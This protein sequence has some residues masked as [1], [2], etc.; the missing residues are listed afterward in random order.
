MKTKLLAL[1]VA[2]MAIVSCNKEANEGAG[3]S[4]RVTLRFSTRAMSD[5]ATRSAASEAENAVE[6]LVVFGLDAEGGVVGAFPVI[7]NPSMTGVELTVPD[8]VVSL[9]VIANPQGHHSLNYAS[10]EEILAETV[11]FSVAPAS[12]FVMSGS[13]SVS[14]AQVDVD[15]VRS[16]AKISVQGNGDFAVNS[17]TVLRTPSKAPLFAGRTNVGEF[18]SHD[19]KAG[20]EVYVGES[21]ASAPAQ[22]LVKGVYKGQPTAY[23]VTLTQ[24]GAP[25][26][27]VRNT[28]YVVGITPLTKT[29][30]LVEV[31]IPEWGDVSGDENLV[32]T[33][34]DYYSVDFHNHTGFSDGT[35]PIAF[36]LNQ[37][38][39][40]GLD[41]IVNSEHGG[42]FSGNASEGDFEGPVPSWTA[43]G[44]L[45][46]I[47]GTPSAGNMWRWQS[48]RDYSFPRV[49]AFNR[50]N[51]ATTI[52]VQGL[53]WNPPGHE[54]CSSGIITGQFE[55]FNNADAMAE[56]EYKFD[57]NDRDVAGGAAQGWTKSAL[58]GHEKSLEA[59]RWMQ[60]NH[61]F[62]SWLVP[63]H[64][65]RQNLW[66]VQDYRDM[67]DAAPD[68]FVAFE[69]VPGHQASTDRGGYGNSSSYDRTWTLGGV[70]VQT[71]QIGNVWDAMLS[72]GRR[73][74]IVANSDFHRHV[75]Q[76]SG[77]FYPG[78]YQ[79]TF[80]SMKE[81]SAQGFVDGLRAGNIYTVHGD[82]IDRLE[83]SVGSATM[84]ET[85]RAG[86]N[87]V[88]VRILVGDPEGTNP[89]NHYSTLT[90]PALD[91]IDLIA[92]K[93][94]AR[95]G[96]GTA[97]YENGTYNDVR[98]IARFDAN[99][100]IEDAGGL[101][102]TKW[103]DLGG[104]LKLVEYTVELDGD[105]YFRLRG[106]NHGLNASGETDANGNP[107]ADTPTGN[108]NAGAS[109]AFNDLW[110][111]SNPVFV[112][113]G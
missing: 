92:G 77:D 56:F 4:N 25:I 6:R 58:S 54:H 66:K 36:V 72:E 107:L 112:R 53:E 97:E 7:E 105:T 22:L 69:S 111:Y 55:A 28:S 73:F 52:A 70:G 8:N 14:G 75:T 3:G 43:S 5:V 44:E 82:L 64:P 80:I 100:G 12:P 26:D 30:C 16:V 85:L 9:R 90:D 86:G 57:N 2:A 71:A 18:V 10:D 29:E 87:S 95:V 106:T 62:T 84:G 21:S 33:F 99:G 41:L 74:W 101:K 13:S 67:N 15:L 40:Y 96:K 23:T 108:V 45:S 35:N 47:I 50:Q 1:A 49:M 63:A 48:I 46:N 65:E 78:E 68:V 94:R 61:R 91:H 83:F 42:Q 79:K 110:F 109:A 76:N 51:Y 11:D 60:K 38:M 27:I 20:S 59:A 102:S 39:R 98:V 89:Y 31:T 104:G 93:M 32:A 34:G 113:K 37:G 19:E 88:K 17:V 103:I 81:R 24:Q